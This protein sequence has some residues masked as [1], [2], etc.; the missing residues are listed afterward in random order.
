MKKNSKTFK[1]ALKLLTIIFVFNAIFISFLPNTV[2]AK[3]DREA[4]KDEL[5]Q[6]EDDLQD[7]LKPYNP[8]DD[9]VTNKVFKNS[10]NNVVKNSKNTKGE[11]ST[12]NITNM[13]Q[14]GLFTIVIKTRTFAIIAY[15][16]IWVIG[17]LYAVV[18]GSRDVNKRRKAFLVIRNTTI[19]FFTYINIPIFII[20]LNTDKTKLTQVTFF[21]IAYSILHFLQNNALIIAVLLVFAGIS[22]LIISKNNLPERKQGIFLIKSAVISF[23]FLSIAP[24]AM[25]FLI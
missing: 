13:I 6:Q 3:S 1:K 23:L 10:V 19:L 15:A 5:E 25:R 2:Y 8:L 18:M 17:I 21:N 24:I 4:L 7:E 11:F 9:K 14:K 22:R 12:K 16:L 20:W